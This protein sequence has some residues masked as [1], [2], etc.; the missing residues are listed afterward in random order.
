LETSYLQVAPPLLA[1]AQSGDAAALTE[2]LEKLRP[3]VLKMAHF[4]ARRCGEDA[5]DLLQEAWLEI[6]EELPRVDGTIGSPEQ[7]LLQRAR[8]RVLDTIKAARV[9]RCPSLDVEQS[10]LGSSAE[11]YCT[12]EV[13]PDLASAMLLADFYSRLNQTQRLILSCLLHGLTWR[14]TGQV[15]GCSSANIAYHVRHI[16]RHYLRWEQE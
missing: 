1:R 16:R 9:R 10:T 2:M 6:L 12:G 11:D 5:D 13:V 4:Y 3:R 7:F 14:E 8:W 15:L